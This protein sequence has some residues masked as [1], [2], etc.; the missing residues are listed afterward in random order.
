MLSKILISKSDFDAVIFDL[1]GVITKT[2]KVHFR[3][4]KRLFDQYLDSRSAGD[5]VPFTDED[6]RRYVD[7]KPRYEAVRSFLE[8]RDIE[9]P[10]GSPDDDPDKE[11]ICGLGNRKNEFFRQSLESGGVEVFAPA[12]QLLHKLRSSGFKTAIVSSSKNCV[13]V[14]KAAGISDLFDEKADG[15]DAQEF[16]L[17]GKPSP[18]IFLVASKRLKVEPQRAVVVED[19]IAGVQAGK[20]GGFGLVI[21][22]DRTGHADGLKQKGADVVVSDLATVQV[23]NRSESSESR[24]PSALKNIQDIASRTQGKR[25]AVFLDY[26][27]TLTPIVD[28][29]EKALLAEPMRKVLITLANHL[30]VA[31]ISGRDLPDVQKLVNIQGVYYAGSHGFDIAGPEGMQSEHQKA[32]KFLPALDKAER[33]LSKRINLIPGAWVER[34]KFSI[35]VH[36]R[37][38]K[39]DEMGSV[40]QAVKEIAALHPDLRQAGGKK[41][42]ELQPRID[43]HK[44]KALLWLLNKMGLDTP[45]VVPFYIGDDVTDE[46][47]F[48]TLPDRGIGIVVMDR[49][50]PTKAHY[51]LNDPGEVERFLKK[52][53]SIQKGGD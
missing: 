36:F 37:K 5:W 13:E 19:A 51:R 45:D 50:G 15:V 31:V 30:P 41:I 53:V 23:E 39:E 47:A 46:D 8:S 24:P 35:A 6:Y 32:T 1:D 12:V 52:M 26:D 25:V 18:D 10:Y 4:W 38:V 44:G 21:G 40:R 17:E 11:T 20:R 43:W 2:A 33:E 29:P 16:K 27:G 3:A 28:D 22:V 9:L 7:G 14:L 49:R 34:K 48:N 42:F